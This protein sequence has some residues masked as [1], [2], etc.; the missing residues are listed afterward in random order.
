[1]CRFIHVH[2]LLTQY[3]LCRQLIKT[4]NV[5]YVILAAHALALLALSATTC[6]QCTF[7]AAAGA[8]ISDVNQ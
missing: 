8:L 4:Y 7:A 6:Q 5:I 3:Q 2:F 1:M